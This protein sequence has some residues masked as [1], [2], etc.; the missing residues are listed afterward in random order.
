MCY[1]GWGAASLKFESK[2]TGSAYCQSAAHLLSKHVLGPLIPGAI[3]SHPLIRGINPILT[4]ASQY[5]VLCQLPGYIPC[6]RTKAELT[7]TLPGMQ[8]IDYC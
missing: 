6:H 1:K 3:S 7:M 4:D 2:T 8:A 5:P